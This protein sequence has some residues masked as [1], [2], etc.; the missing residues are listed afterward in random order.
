MGT[1]RKAVDLHCRSCIVDDVVLG[2]GS[3]RKQVTDCTSYDCEL[4]PFRPVD[5]DEKARRKQDKI[6]NMSPSEL[7]SYRAKQEDCRVRLHRTK[8]NEMD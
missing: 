1:L 2:N 5:R 6:D 3:W 7:K 8:T 4:F